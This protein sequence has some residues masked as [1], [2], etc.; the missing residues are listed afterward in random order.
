MN[1]QQ[2]ETQES[3]SVLD[4]T[5]QLAGDLMR[6]SKKTKMSESGVKD[7]YSFFYQQVEMERQRSARPSQ[8]SGQDLIDAI[9]QEQ[10]D[11]TAH[12]T[13]NAE[14]ITSDD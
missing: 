7:I 1:M 3:I 5:E 13:L 12:E 9:A 14:V 11:A 10:A 6:I 2:E 8:P 4:A